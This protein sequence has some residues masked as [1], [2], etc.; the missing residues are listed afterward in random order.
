N[1]HEVKVHRVTVRITNLGSHYVRI[2]LDLRDPKLHE[3]NQ[4]LLRA[5][6]VMSITPVTCESIDG[7]NSWQHLTE[8][9]K[10]VVG[11]LRQLFD[12]DAPESMTQAEGEADIDADTRF[13][14]LLE[15]RS[16]S[17]QGKN[18]DEYD[19]TESEIRNFAGPLFLQPLT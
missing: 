5:S 19:A 2:E 9:T 1:G 12:R 3:I 16:A 17:T 7:S 10:S 6:N 4:A 8:Y 14:V 18:G 15:V 11:S 13:H